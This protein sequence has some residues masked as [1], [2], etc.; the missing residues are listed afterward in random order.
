MAANERQLFGLSLASANLFK[1]IID[2]HNEEIF[3]IPDYAAPPCTAVQKRIIFEDGLYENNE[4][5]MP[6][7]YFNFS[8][9][10]Q[11]PI[12]TDRSFRVKP[13]ITLKHKCY[14][15]SHYRVYRAEVSPRQA[16]S[17]LREQLFVSQEAT[18][19]GA[20]SVSFL[21][22]LWLI[23]P[24]ETMSWQPCSGCSAFCCAKSA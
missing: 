11:F 7:F 16:A 19:F 9:F 5:C 21:T 22:D 1:T 12:I 15:V 20:R 4:V 6:A 13:N 2:A 3:S 18:V 23:S 17:L 8:C 10:H 24:T 14:V